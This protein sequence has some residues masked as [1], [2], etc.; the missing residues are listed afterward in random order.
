MGVAFFRRARALR[1][2][3]VEANAP[4]IIASSE[5]AAPPVLDDEALEKATRPDE[6]PKRP[7]QAKGR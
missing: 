4:R 1:D 7:A 6:Q 2:V 3:M 5:A